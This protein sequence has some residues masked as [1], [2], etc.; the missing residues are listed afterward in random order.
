MLMNR[1]DPPPIADNYYGN[2]G[3]TADSEIAHSEQN[4]CGTAAMVSLD[5]ECRIRRGRSRR[6]PIRTGGWTRRW[7]LQF[8]GL[9]TNVSN[10]GV[11]DNP[12]QYKD[13]K[14]GPQYQW[15]VEQLSYCKT[16]NASGT[17]QAI[18]LALH[19][20]P[21]KSTLDFQQRGNPT[22]GLND[23]AYPNAVPIGMALQEALA[24]SG[25]I[26]DAIFSAHAHL[27]QRM[28]LSYNDSHGKP[29]QQVPC[30]VVG[31][32]GH[33]QLELMAT[34][35]AGGTGKK[36]S[37]RL[38]STCSVRGNSAEGPE[39]AGE[40]HGDDR[41]LCRWDQPEQSAVRLLDRYADARETRAQTSDA[42]V[43]VLHDAVR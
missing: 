10:G 19:Y 35:C 18:L 12:T 21:Y 23:N 40:C 1:R 38:R 27:Y 22:F 15:L 16:Q 33:T 41:V 6:C 30:F 14:D 20:P 29:V 25:Q 4:M 11:L 43:P 2:T 34:L 3:S 37:W 5:K 26:P 42:G 32:G 7:R 36:F 9:Y 13:P 17:S 31:C 39:R 24:K 8:I 28:T